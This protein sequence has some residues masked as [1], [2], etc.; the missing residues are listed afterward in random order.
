MAGQ[1]RLNDRAL[2]DSSRYAIVHSHSLTGNAINARKS[3]DTSLF[4]RNYGRRELLNLAGDTS[5]PTETRKAELVEGIERDSDLSEMFNA[6][7]LY[8]R[9]C[10]DDVGPDFHMCNRAYIGFY[11]N[12][13]RRKLCQEDSVRA[14]DLG[15]DGRPLVATVRGNQRAESEAVSPFSIR[16]KGPKD[17]PSTS[18][19]PITRPAGRL[20]ISSRAKWGLATV[21]SWKRVPRPVLKLRA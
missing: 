15:E 2:P 9:N 10:T 21:W 7:D 5:P 20:N 4:V 13:T 11:P 6:A 1:N 12:P 18:A 16:S 17:R 8:I 19:P 14:E 3:I